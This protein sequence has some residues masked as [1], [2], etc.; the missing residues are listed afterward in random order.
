MSPKEL[1]SLME[2]TRTSSPM[3]AEAL[4]IAP[5]QVRK[6]RA[7]TRPVPQRHIPAMRLLFRD[8]AAS[9][10]LEPPSLP[11]KPERVDAREVVPT[12]IEHR[13][14]IEGR[15]EPLPLAAERVSIVEVINGLVAGLAPRRRV[16]SV[17]APIAAETEVA[18]PIARPQPS[19]LFRRDDRSPSAR[20]I[21]RPPGARHPQIIDVMPLGPPPAP[22]TEPPG[23]GASGRIPT[24]PVQPQG[25]ASS[26]QRLARPIVRCI[27]CS[28][29]GSGRASVA[30]RS[31]PV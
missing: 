5:Q 2:R 7:G 21:V 4:G 9:L 28:M 3:L 24:P 17:L 29:Y 1:K 16:D 20:P 23:R 15:D 11:E 27:G 8:R 6:W 13:I 18:A 14:T 25:R 31:S 30:P 26:W 22:F 19:S 12:P 10:G